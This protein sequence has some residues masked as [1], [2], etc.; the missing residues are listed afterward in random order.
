MNQ[1]TST[2]A[3]DIGAKS[4]P[5]RFGHLAF[6]AALDLFGFWF[7]VLGSSALAH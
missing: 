7:L 1:T 4:R 2:N 3:Q 6:D 5:I